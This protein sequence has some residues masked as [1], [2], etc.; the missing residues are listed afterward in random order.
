MS[1]MNSD[2]QLI[3]PRP[4]QT[5][6]LLEHAASRNQ[7][8]WRIIFAVSSRD[9]LLGKLAGLDTSNSTDKHLVAH[10][11]LDLLCKMGL[12]SGSSNHL[13][14]CVVSAAGD[15][16]DID[17]A[18][19][20]DLGQLDALVDGP[21]VSAPLRVGVEPV[22][23]ADADE[24]RHVLGDGF[25]RGID[26][27]DGEAGAVLEATAVLIGALVDGGREE[28]RDEIA[29]GEMQ[30]NDV[31]AGTHGAG[32]AGE[33]VL[34]ELVDLGDGHGP[35]CGIVLAEGRVAGADDVGGPSSYLLGGGGSGA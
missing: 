1:D 11:G 2:I 16:E 9:G 18:V 19:G 25:A 31:E 7:I 8:Q 32:H 3:R 27:L 33:E 12:V 4:D 29:V 30:F 35:R 13:L 28:A 21:A 23:G 24:Q 22:G 15:V 5:R 10:G 6:V 14:V 26:E 20:E 17:T 34:L